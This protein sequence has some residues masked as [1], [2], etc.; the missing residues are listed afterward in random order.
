M[1]YE[2][3][4]AKLVK[5]HSRSCSYK[6][7]FATAKRSITTE[8]ELKEVLKHF[9]VIFPSPEFLMNVTRYQ[10]IGEGL[11]VNDILNNESTS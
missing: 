4:V 11:N 3:N 8:F 1:Y 10:E 2:I 6:H 5:V 9:L 7:F